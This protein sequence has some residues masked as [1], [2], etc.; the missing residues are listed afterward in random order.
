VIWRG[1]QDHLVVIY[2]GNPVLS[3]VGDPFGS[4]LGCTLCLS[5]TARGGLS[6]G[7]SVS[8]MNVNAIVGGG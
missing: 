8:T 7:M 5:W 6:G 1:G 3:N 4:F 2:A